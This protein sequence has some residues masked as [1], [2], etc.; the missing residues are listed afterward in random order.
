MPAKKRLRIIGGAWGG[1]KLP[2]E[3]GVRPSPDRVR[4]T[5][6]NWLR[7][8]LVGAHVLD[9]FAGS[10]A[11][12][13]EALSQGAAH[14]TFVEQDRKIARALQASR[15]TLAAHA[16]IEIADAH[17]W[18]KRDPTRQFDVVFLDPPFQT[19]KYAGLVKALLPHLASTGLLY[20]ESDTALDFEPLEV[21]RAARAGA[22]HFALYRRREA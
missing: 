6:F 19:S 20:V 5:L 12:G 2:I 11:L 16:S 8:S 17:R 9:L 21:H 15:E 14:A 1:R 10:G 4:E 7:P 3:N 13:F 22:V 18:L